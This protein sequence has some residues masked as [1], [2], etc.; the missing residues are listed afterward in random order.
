MLTRSLGRRDLVSLAAFA[1]LA[2]LAGSRETTME[3][4]V[5]ST[6]ER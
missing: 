4:T 5:Q 1:P 2:Q 3:P 6:A